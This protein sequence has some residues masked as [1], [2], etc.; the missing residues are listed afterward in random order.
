[1]RNEVAI[2]IPTYNQPNHL[3]I[4]L[5]SILRW[6]KSSIK[7]YVIDNSESKY[8]EGIAR[9]LSEA[10][11]VHKAEKNLGWMG[12]IN[13]GIEISTEPHILMLNDD[14]RIL[15]FDSQW[16]NK[17][18]NSLYSTNLKAG[19]VGPCSNWIMGTQNMEATAHAKLVVTSALSGMCLLTTRDVINEI[20]GLD[21]SLPGGDDLDFSIRLRK[22]GYVMFSQRDVFVYH[23]GSLTGKSI[24]GNHWN[25]PSYS[26]AVNNALIRKHGFKWFMQSYSFEEPAYAP[27]PCEDWERNTM[28]PYCVGKGADI[29]CGNNKVLP[30]AI[31]IDLTPKDE[32][33]KAGS[34]LGMK[35]QADIA[36][37]DL[38]LPF[39]DNSLDYIHSRHVVEHIVDIVSGLREWVRVLKPNGKLILAAPDENIC[40]GIPLDPTH[41]HAFTLDSFKNI[42]RLITPFNVIR[43]REDDF[44]WVLVVEVLK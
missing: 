25:S 18:M 26:E 33:G 10:I 4:T 34:Q 22:A 28:L 15:D 42:L 7:I 32:L 31:G 38:N 41:K 43:E 3:A 1:M 6:T 9:Q 19:A 14:I 27:S 44:S 13:K 23:Y 35:S 16:L 24:Y 29:G 8:A 36:V 21:E 30:E 20:G 17:L 12:G 40:D 5:T 37:A 39:D 11:V 2:I